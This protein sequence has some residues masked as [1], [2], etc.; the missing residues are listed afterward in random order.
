MSVDGA[1][2]GRRAHDQAGSEAASPY[3]LDAADAEGNE[4]DKEHEAVDAEGRHEDIEGRRLP[5]DPNGES[6]MELCLPEDDGRVRRKPH[7]C[8][9]SNRST[10]MTF[11]CPPRHR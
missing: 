3:E 1:E 9:K 4:A 7:A 2:S 10:P 6:P 11:T 5:D 8:P